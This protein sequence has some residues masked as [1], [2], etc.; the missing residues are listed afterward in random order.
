MDGWLSRPVA[1]PVLGV[2]GPELT[3]NMVI[4]RG[5]GDVLSPWSTPFTTVL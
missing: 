4:D 5:T 1:T 3:A 2:T